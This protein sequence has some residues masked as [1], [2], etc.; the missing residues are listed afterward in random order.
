VSFLRND[1]SSPVQSNAFE[2]NDRITYQLRI[3]IAG[4]GSNV[5][6]GSYDGRTVVARYRQDTPTGSL[7]AANATKFA[8]KII[9]TH[10]AYNP[11]TGQFTCPVAG[12]YQIVGCI[13]AGGGASAGGSLLF[14]DAYKNGSLYSRGQLAIAWLT[15]TINTVA[16]LDVTVQCNAGDTLE[17]RTDTPGFTS[18]SFTTDTGRN[19]V[20]FRLLPGRSTLAAGD[21]VPPKVTRYTSGSGTHNVAADTK[22]LRVRMLAGGG[23]GG[24]NSTTAGAAAGGAGGDTTFGT[25]VAKGGTGG[26]AANANAAPSGTAAPDYV[27]VNIYRSDMGQSGGRNPS[28]T[29][30]TATGGKGGS[31]FLGGGGQ[32]NGGGTGFAAL[33]NTGGGGGGGS[34]IAGGANDWAGSGGNS[35]EGIEFI[36]YN[37]L[38]SYSYTVGIGGN[39]GIGGTYNGGPGGSGV[40][41]VEEYS[42]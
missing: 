20:E 7:T 33:P 23:G 4:W 5:Q 13:R 37:P 6:I 40:L 42:R 28:G 39:G 9:D 38:P 32:G 41:I 17:V 1:T 25:A 10:N 15:G 8:D 29:N 34:S 35:G 16:S 24:G 36:I 30:A 14:L 19:F 11:S 26:A 22:Y 3:P 31:S 27:V 2:T 12:F 18:P 21:Y